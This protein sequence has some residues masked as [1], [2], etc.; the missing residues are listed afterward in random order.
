VEIP[1][2]SVQSGG[3]PNA[4]RET[5]MR[6][7]PLVGRAELVV[8]GHGAP[9]NRVQAQAVLAQDV[10]YLDALLVV[11]G[12][13]AAEVTLPEGRRSAAQKRIHAANLAAVV[14]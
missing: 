13:S 7:A 12:A 14:S 6:F 3:S 1:M 5:L 4:Y 10:A 11:G 2:I 8:P 9:L